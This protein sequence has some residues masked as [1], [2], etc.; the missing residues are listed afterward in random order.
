M[1]FA[2]VNGKYFDSE[3]SPTVRNMMIQ[4]GKITGVGYIPDED[5]DNLTIVD[6]TQS[7]I[8]PNTFDFVFSSH[9]SK[10]SNLIHDVQSNGVFNIGFI[11][12]S[13]TNCLDDPMVIESIANHTLTSGSLSIFACAT[14]QNL[15]NELAEL[16]MLKKAGASG[17]YFGRILENE[18]LLKQAL[19]YVDMIG[20]PIVVAPLTRFEADGTHLNEGVSSFTVGVRGESVN[21]EFR[22]VQT[23]L[24]LIKETTTVPVHFLAISSAEAIDLIDQFKK[25]YPNVSV[26]VSPFHMALSDEA[27]LTYNSDLKFNPPLRHSDEILKLFE[28]F[29]SNKI[30]HVTSLHAPKNDEPQPTSFF[31]SQPY[32]S[33]IASYYNVV[34]HLFIDSGLDLNNLKTLLS[35]PKGFN[36]FSE[37]TLNL[38]DQANFVAIKTQAE[39]AEIKTIFF[40]VALELK[41]GVSAVVV[42]GELR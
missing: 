25:D 5:E 18:S 33:T 17:I 37:N 23:L 35:A 22:R 30:D 12:N 21:D 6:I 15:P 14:K 29:K 16:S 36:L 3:K 11:P 24:S 31:D 4:N 7:L 8:L 38:N 42:S 40:N 39:E 34:S 20:C 19:T 41:G 9:P 13:Q 32:L 10:L 26:G 2:V 27:L 1:G 28:L